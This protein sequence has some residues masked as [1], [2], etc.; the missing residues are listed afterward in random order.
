MNYKELLNIATHKIIYNTNDLP[1][2]AFSIALQ[3]GI[4]LKNS[5]ECKEDFK[6]SY[7]LTHTNALYALYKNEYTI[8]YDENFPYKNFAIAHE[9]AHHLLNHTT[10]GAAQHQEAQL[11]AAILIAPPHLINTNKIKSAINLSETCKMPIDI[12]ERYWHEINNCHS[13]LKQDYASKTLMSIIA[14]AVI[15]IGSISLSKVKNNI[16]RRNL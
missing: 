11:L 12:A 10:D 6:D 13:V 14:S 3:Q 1:Q 9:I 4:R 8:Y 15:I 5:I 16:N 2:N 7:P